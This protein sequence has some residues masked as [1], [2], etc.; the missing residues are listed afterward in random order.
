MI[1]SSSYPPESPPSIF[2]DQWIKSLVMNMKDRFK[3][4][5]NKEITQRFKNMEIF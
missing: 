4:V 5:T 3:I 1:F 2:C